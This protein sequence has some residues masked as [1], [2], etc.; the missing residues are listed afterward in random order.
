M[1]SRAYAVEDGNLQKTTILTTRKKSYSDI[2]LTFSKKPAGDIYKKFHAAAVKQ[3]VKNLL[4]TN[5]GEKPF[6]QYFGGN[7]N[8]FLFE[9]NDGLVEEDIEDQVRQAISNYEPRAEVL[10]VKCRSNP[11]RNDIMVTTTFK[12]ISTEEIVSLT[13]DLARLR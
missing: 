5:Y 6:D 2:D 13:V 3:A 4:M 7:L 10:N 9:L 12:V 11:D 1:V 8:N